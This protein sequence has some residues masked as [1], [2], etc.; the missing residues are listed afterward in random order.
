MSNVFLKDTF[1]YLGLNRFLS[2]FA[3]YKV[4]NRFFFVNI[5]L[6]SCYKVNMKEEN[7]SEFNF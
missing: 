4:N 2:I 7:Q 1:Y 6:I 5:G 3:K